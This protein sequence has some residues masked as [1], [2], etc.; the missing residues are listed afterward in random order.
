MKNDKVSNHLSIQFLAAIAAT[1][2]LVATDKG[3]LS[4]P[5]EKKFKSVFIVIIRVCQGGEPP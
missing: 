2:G 1:V 3:G 4:S 5:V